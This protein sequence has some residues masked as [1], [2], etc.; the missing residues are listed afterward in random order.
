[1]EATPLSA[2]DAVEARELHRRPDDA[3]EK[4]ESSRATGKKPEA[5][6]IL[7][8]ETR[9]AERGSSPSS[10]SVAEAPRAASA[11]LQAADKQAEL[12]NQQELLELAGAIVVDGRTLRQAYD[13]HLISE[14]G[15]RRLVAEYRRNGDM[16]EAL[17]REITE[18]EIDFERDPAMR[19]LALS[20]TGGSS[21]DT[22]PAAGADHPV[23]AEL[24]QQATAANDAPSGEHG[25]PAEH[26]ESPDPPP[27]PPTGP[28]TETTPL[29]YGPIIDVAI[30]V[31]IIVLVLLVLIVYLTRH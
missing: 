29:S 11:N 22:P 2:E 31:L 27:S 17:K 5:L 16:H 20:A 15:L 6:G 8:V 10:S 3:P 24:V 9:S 18:H 4:P 19:D 13:L 14:R 26:K 28:P 30:A 25:Q 23:I 7:A 21:S 1:M 12:L